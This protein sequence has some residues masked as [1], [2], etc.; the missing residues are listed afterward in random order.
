MTQFKQA[1]KNGKTAYFS[2][3]GPDKLFIDGVEM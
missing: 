2:R 3:A 1:K